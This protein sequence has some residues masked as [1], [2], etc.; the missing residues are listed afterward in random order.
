MVNCDTVRKNL[1]VTVDSELYFILG[2]QLLFLLL[3][4]YVL[5]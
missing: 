2:Q 5:W 3:I 1:D 4:C